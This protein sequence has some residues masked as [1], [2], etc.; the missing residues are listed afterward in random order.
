M[1]M[2][3]KYA[4][5]LGKGYVRLI[6]RGGLDLRSLLEINS[7]LLL[8]LCWKFLSSDDDWAR[9]CRTRHLRGGIPS[10][11]YL[12]S[13][14]WPGLKTHLN[15]VMQNSLWLIGT[16]EKIRFWTDTWLEAPLAEMLHLPPALRASLTAP[17]SSFVINGAWRM[18]D[19]INEINPVVAQQIKQVILP[20]APLQDRLVWFNSK[21]GNLSAKQAAAFYLSLPLFRDL[22]LAMW[23]AKSCLTYHYSHGF[24]NGIRFNNSIISVHAA[25]TKILTSI[26]TSAP[27]LDG[28]TNS[29]TELLIISR[30]RIQ[31]K[32]TT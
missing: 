30:F 18:S 20:K 7:S 4:Q 11:S 27:L 8:H 23:V 26:A 32:V 29:S 16:G 1:L 19:C 24:I 10:M 5:F 21:D 14:I 31:P 17:V 13:S 28:S 12:L 15:T 6:L 22:E 9:L 2:F 3:G 25:K